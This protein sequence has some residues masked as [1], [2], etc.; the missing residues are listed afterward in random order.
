MLRNESKRAIIF[1]LN[2][3]S[4]Q[5]SVFKTKIMKTKTFSW[6][7][8]ILF[9]ASLNACRNSGPSYSER[10]TPQPPVVQEVPEEDEPEFFDQSI[11]NE[12]EIEPPRTAEAPPPPPPPP[13]IEKEVA[14]ELFIP[15]EPEPSQESPSL[16]GNWEDSSDEWNTEDYA[17]IQENDFQAVL[18]HPLSTFSVDV[19]RA[20]YANVRRFLRS[21]Q[22]PAPGVVRIEEMIN[23]FDYSYSAPTDNAPFA[24]HTEM[25]SCPWNQE[26]QLLR[27][28]LQGKKIPSTQIPPSNLVFLLDV[29]GSMDMPNKLPLLK[30]AFRLLTNQLRSEDRV[31][32]VVYAGASGVVLPATPGHQ[33]ATILDALEQLEA[34]GS[35]AGAEG[36]QL[37]YKIARE[38]LIKGGNNRVILATDGDFNV[39]ASSDA[40]LVKLIEKERADGIFLSVLGFGDGNYKDNKM[41]QIANKG[42]GNYAYIDNILEAKKVL[43]KEFSS[44]LFTIAKDVKLQL[45]FNP[46]HVKS[47]RL[48]G[49]E[50]RI[51]NKEDFND[52]TKDAGEIG[53]G[54]S[55]TALYELMPVG[56]TETTASVDPLEF[57]EQKV[58]VTAKNNPNWISLKLRYKQPNEETSQLLRF[59][60]QKE[61]LTFEQASEDT[62]FAVAVA[63]FGMLLRKSKYGSDLHFEQII[64]IAKKAKGLDEEGYRAEFIQLAELAEGL[65]GN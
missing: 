58:K 10:T 9:F 38:N 51:L 41:E 7:A 11:A 53:A 34:G 17:N 55:V 33:K 22:W 32:I 23:Y 12:I 8:T 29:S 65:G 44:T 13:P 42:N 64:R 4:A 46:A 47:Y 56:A 37:S 43:V 62:R 52:D 49:Y 35:T 45:E 39:G 24:V 54:H 59:Y 57:Q 48:I 18:D 3:P 21:N 14:A 16:M 31:A 50:N 1:Y 5:A 27:I 28:G 36:I 19:D 2:Q 60:A 40:A 63:G 61:D 15:R 6:I 20:S 30:R 25:V 26:H